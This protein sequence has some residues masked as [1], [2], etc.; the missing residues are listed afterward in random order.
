[1]AARLAGAECGGAVRELNA[2]DG[3]LLRALSGGAD[4]INDSWSLVAAGNPVFV[5][6]YG[7][8]SVAE[9]TIGALAGPRQERLAWLP[10]LSQ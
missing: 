10:G 3:S 8:D 6:N 1:M 5:V 2:G 7:I 9:L 4:G